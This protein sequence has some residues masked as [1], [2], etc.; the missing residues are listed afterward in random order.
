[1]QLGFIKNR[2]KEMMEGEPTF[3]IV[4]NGYYHIDTHD[5]KWAYFK[6]VCTLKLIYL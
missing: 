1:M 5:R 2:M 4:N 3:P 6:K